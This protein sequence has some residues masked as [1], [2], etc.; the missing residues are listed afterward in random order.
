VGTGIALALAV[1]A[2]VLAVEP[3]AV[4]VAMAPVTASAI[5]RLRTMTFILILPFGYS[6][7]VKLKKISGL[8][9]WN[10]LRMSIL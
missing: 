4:V 6:E 10:N 5:T 9:R 8:A 1:I 2:V 7:W 3:L